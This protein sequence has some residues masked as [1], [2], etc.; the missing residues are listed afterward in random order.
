MNKKLFI[1]LFGMLLL[2]AALGGYLIG[3]Y[4]AASIQYHSFNAI[5]A[6]FTADPLLMLDQNIEDCR[7][8]LEKR[9]DYNLNELR[10][11]KSLMLNMDFIKAA[12]LQK[13]KLDPSLIDRNEDMVREYV[14]KH[15]KNGFRLCFTN[16]N[17]PFIPPGI[18]AQ[19]MIVNMPK[20]D[21]SAPTILKWIKETAQLLGDHPDPRYE[22]TL[23]YGIDSFKT[24][25]ELQA[26]PVDLKFTALDGNEVDLAKMRGKVVLFDFWAT[27]CGACVESIPEVQEAYKKYNDRG[28]EIVGFS[29][30][31]DKAKLESFL[32]EK[33]MSWPEFFDGKASMAQ[34][35]G[36]QGIPTL[37]LF[38]KQGILVERDARGKLDARIPQLLSE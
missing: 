16:S 3:F 29:S 1:M 10:H 20:S 33:G 13:A 6:A 38:N 2:V 9:L 19:Q 30:D 36:I 25:A 15:P 23:R 17:G 28:F 4:R 34:R 35:F 26:R 11:P 32:K 27:W 12:F 31:S 21:A 37:W 5:V 14:V 24:L 7:Y 18:Q 22:K 8:V